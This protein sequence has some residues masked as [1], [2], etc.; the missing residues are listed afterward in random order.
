MHFEEG[1]VRSEVSAVEA[2]IR[3]WTGAGD[4]WDRAI[5]VGQSLRKNVASEPLEIGAVIHPF[6][7][8]CLARHIDPYGKRDFARAPLL[9]A[10]G[11]ISIAPSY[12]RMSA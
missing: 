2:G 8:D 4:D 12:D 9:F 5:A 6:L 3:M 7:R 1:G 11:T 10:R